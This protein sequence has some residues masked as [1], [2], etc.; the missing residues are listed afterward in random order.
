MA[1]NGSNSCLPSWL[2]NLAEAHAELGQLDEAWRCIGEAMTQ[3]KQ[4]KKDGSRPRS[5]AS[6]AKSRLSRRSRMRRKRKHI[7]SVLWRLRVNRR[8]SPWNYAPQ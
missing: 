5:I 8:R 3:P 6:R 2:S 1:V 7:S 4:P